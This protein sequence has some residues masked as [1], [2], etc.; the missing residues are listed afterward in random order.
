[1]VDAA[2]ERLLPADESGGR[3]L[4]AMRYSI[5][6]G[7]KRLRPILCLAGAEAVGGDPAKVMFCACAM[8]MVHTYSLIHDDL[9]AMDDDEFRRG[10]PTSHM[11]YGEGMA[12]LAG[13]GLLTQAMVLLSDPGETA[14]LDPSRVLEA[15]QVVMKA[16]GYLGM[17]GGQAVD[18]ASENL[19]PDLATVQYMHAMKTG[20][21]ITASV[22]SGAILAGGDPEQV[23]KL[24]R[25]GR[26]IGLAFQI[27]DDLLDLEGDFDAL[28]KTVGADQARG[29]M[30]Y[31]AVVGPAQ[32]RNMGQELVDQAAAIADGLGPQAAPLA[33]LARYIMARTH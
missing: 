27:A 19:R 20:A 8:E 17:V 28:G 12:V 26:R 5:F 22:Q 21:L 4:E 10:V 25:Y 23:R 15:S 33:E 3:I 13:D 29:K 11:V 14:G 30:T 32:A 6:A 1:M 7:G 9:P 24:V 16:A 31:P 18:L 2:L